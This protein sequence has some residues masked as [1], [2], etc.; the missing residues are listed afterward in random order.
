MRMMKS[1]AV[2][3][4]LL[5]IA[6][7]VVPEGYR[8][9]P[10]RGCQ[11]G[12][13]CSDEQRQT[14]TCCCQ[15]SAAT[16][17]PE[18][19]EPPSCCSKS[20]GEPRSCCSTR[21]ATSPTSDPNAADTRSCCGRKSAAG[22]CAG[23]ADRPVPETASLGKCPCGDGPSESSV[24]HAP[25]VPVLNV[26]VVASSGRSERVSGIRATMQADRCPPPV[27]PPRTGFC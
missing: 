12:C 6:T 5:L 17:T 22:C 7:V 19:T 8:P 16:K 26:L 1:L 14:G 21:S 10:A 15:T 18:Q 25:R 4:I 23:K 3:Q 27:P 13:G 20:D 24:L 2:I 11:N 9:A